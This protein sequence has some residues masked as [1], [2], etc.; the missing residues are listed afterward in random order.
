[1]QYV[2]DTVC[3]AI[4]VYCGGDSVFDAKCQTSGCSTLWMQYTVE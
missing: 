2:L 3:S 4:V 1:M